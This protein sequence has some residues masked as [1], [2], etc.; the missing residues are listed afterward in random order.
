MSTYC[1]SCQTFPHVSLYNYM[2]A[3]KCDKCGDGRK[4][5][6]YQLNCCYKKYDY[7]NT[8]TK[9]EMKCDNDDNACKMKF[10]AETI[11]TEDQ[12]FEYLVKKFSNLDDRIEKLEDKINDFTGY[13][14]NNNNYDDDQNTLKN[15][16]EKIKDKVDNIDDVVD[17]IKYAIDDLMDELKSLNRNVDNSNSEIKSELSEVSNMIKYAPGMGPGYFEA[18]TSYNKLSNQN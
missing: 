6:Y 11:I 9:L 5:K 13:G 1:V 17:R 14:S 15:D 8:C 10:L 18:E 3:L 12:K 7:C 4:T 16:I 2:H